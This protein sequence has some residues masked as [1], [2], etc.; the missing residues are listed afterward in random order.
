MNSWAR[1]LDDRRQSAKSWVRSFDNHRKIRERGT[2]GDCADRRRFGSGR[3][4]TAKGPSGSA[5]GAKTSQ[6]R[7]T[8]WVT[9]RNG[10]SPVRAGQCCAAPTGLFRFVAGDPGRCPGLACLRTLGAPFDPACN[11]H[12]RLWDRMGL[13]KSWARCLDDRRQSTKS[14][15]QCLDRNRTSS[16]SNILQ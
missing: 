1:C 14:W 15:T 16:Q 12:D 8:P 5:K 7:A 4:G 13:V 9:N 11:G 3:S 6:P 2:T 10:A